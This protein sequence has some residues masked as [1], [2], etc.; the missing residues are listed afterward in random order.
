M[1]IKTN[2]SNILRVEAD[3]SVFFKCE[4]SG[5]MSNIES[6]INSASNE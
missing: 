5:M 2:T 1:L 4:H 3:L 6:F